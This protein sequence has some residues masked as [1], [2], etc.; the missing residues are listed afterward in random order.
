MT[1]NLSERPFDEII[2][3]LISSPLPENVLSF[4]PSWETQ[5]KLNNLVQKNEEGNLEVEEAKELE[6]FLMIEHLLRLAKI[7]AKQ[8]LAA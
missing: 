2:D 6:Q 8:K 5:M 7:K 4:K 1:T 3:F